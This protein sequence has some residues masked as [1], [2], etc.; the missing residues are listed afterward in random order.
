MREEVGVGGE[1]VLD[2]SFHKLPLGLD[3]ALSLDQDSAGSGAVARVFCLLEEHGLEVRET[4]QGEGDAGLAHADRGPQRVAEVAD[5]VGAEL[6]GVGVV[7]LDAA[8][9]VGDGEHRVV[10]VLRV[11]CVEVGAGGGRGTC[12]RP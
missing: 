5:A 10:R 2:A 11:V 9:E 6:V 3:A 4:R 7:L 8:C 1:D 12:V